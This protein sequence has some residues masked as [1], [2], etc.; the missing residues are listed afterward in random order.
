MGFK[1]KSKNKNSVLKFVNSLKLF[2]Y[3][4]SWGGFESLALYQAHDALGKRQFTNL[5]K[6][7][8]VIRMHIG[9]ED[10]IDIIKDIK[11]ALK[12]VK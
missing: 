7:E 10:P 9:L 1:I 6:D 4:F 3:G 2:G 8:H 11:Q 5:N 12:Y